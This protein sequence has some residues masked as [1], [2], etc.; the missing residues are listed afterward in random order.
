M[1]IRNGSLKPGTKLPS[2]PEL[3][4]RYHISRS[5]LREALKML[6][7][8]RIIISLNGVG[9]FI[10]TYPSIIENPLN[11]LSSLGEMIHNAGLQ[12]SATDVKVYR[13]N[14]ELEWTQKLQTSDPVVVVE[15]TRIADDIRVA[16]YYNIIPACIAGD[17]ITENFRDSIF[18]FLETQTGLRINYC[19]SEIIAP[20]ASDPM[21]YKAMTILGPQIIK[22][23]QLHFDTNNQPVLYSM[24]YL[25]SG[26]I[27]LI[28]NRER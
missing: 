14:P 2:E 3:A 5:T 10:N 4:R 25:K 23:K 8:E 18:T 17:S 28:V 26:I 27:K 24:D 19:I 13:Q 21:D 15:R 12:E 11:Q 1:K 22:L 7:K 6:Q 20:I 16:F 9:T